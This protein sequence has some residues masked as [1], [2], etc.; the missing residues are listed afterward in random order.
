MYFAFILFQSTLKKKKIIFFGI[1]IQFV[2][3]GRICI[4]FFSLSMLD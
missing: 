3:G 1:R 4:R 2:F